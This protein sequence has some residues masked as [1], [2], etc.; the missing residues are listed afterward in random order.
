MTTST[1]QPVYGTT[2]GG[3][4]PENYERYFVPA[5]GRPFAADLVEAA[6]L[7][8]GERVL[9]IACG[10]GV[11]AR[12]AAERVGDSGSVAGL[13]VNAGMLAVARVSMP[14]RAR[15]IRWYESSAEAM[16][17]PDASFD[18]VLCQLG[19]Q[20]MADKPSAL[21]EMRRVVASGGRILISVPTPTAFFEVLETALTRHVPAASGFVR[22]V[23]AL[24]DAAEV[25]A[26]LQGAGFVDVRVREEA[27]LLDLPSPGEFLWQY[28][29][30]TP[31]VG[32]V[33]AREDRQG[34]ALER[35]VV[36]AWQPWVH[37]AGMQYEQGMIVAAGHTR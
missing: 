34:A 9:D 23:F 13:D 2:Y 21:R 26:L 6:Q 10:T 28:I 15:P 33:P 35:D 16:P 20:F 8:N 7:R 18:V 17:L 24:N 4:A 27:K 12:L 31:L 37:D 1:S 11:V 32:M 30:S 25:E 22:M 36:A 14:P 5:I 29:H 3:S 19:L